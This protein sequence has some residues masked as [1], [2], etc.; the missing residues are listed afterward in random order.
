MWRVALQPQGP[1]GQISDSQSLP[2]ATKNNA[3]V[4]QANTV[5]SILPP[6]W[7]LSPAP[8]HALI[9]TLI[10]FRLHLDCKFSESSTGIFQSQPRRVC[11]KAC[12]LIA[13][14]S[15][16]SDPGNSFP[17]GPF[18]ASDQLGGMKNVL[19]SYR[20]MYTFP[21]SP[22]SCPGLWEGL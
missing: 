1:P 8:T 3:Q 13:D 4:P 18:S 9:H 15:T 17:Q 7:Y 14:L 2:R 6:H 20:N 16:D 19:K 12:S 21:G 5:W 10:P 22:C 11:G